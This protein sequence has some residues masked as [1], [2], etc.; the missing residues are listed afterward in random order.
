MNFVSGAKNWFSNLFTHNLIRL[1]SKQ[2]LKFRHEWV[3][4]GGLGKE[5]SSCWEGFI[6]FNADLFID[7]F[8]VCPF[9]LKILG[10][11]SCFGS[12]PVPDAFVDKQPLYIR[13]APQIVN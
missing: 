8:L 2:Y 12:S 13:T 10:S 5:V 7:I 9:I 3:W 4:G 6:L 1:M 11:I